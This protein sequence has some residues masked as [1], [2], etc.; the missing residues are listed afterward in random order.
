MVTTVNDA[1][2]DIRQKLR[3]AEIAGSD[4][5]ARELICKAL[6]IDADRFYAKRGEY[7]FDNKISQLKELVALRL[8]GVP[9]QH[10]TGRWEFYGLD[11]KVTPDTLIPR[12]DTETLVDA[13]LA[14][15]NIRP[16]VRVLDLCCGTGCV[17]IAVARF[18]HSPISGL[19]AD[20]SP[21]A[22]HVARENA[23]RNRVS[24]RM[25]VAECDARQPCPEVFGSF[26]LIVCNP[27]Y[28]PSGE[29]D[30]LD[31]EVRREPH[32]ALDGGPD[33]LDF[34]RAVCRNFKAAVREGGAL[35]FEVGLAQH[36]AV[37]K[38][39]VDAGFEDIAVF[40][41]LTGIE[42]VVCGTAPYEYEMEM[43]AELPEITN[44]CT[45][46]CTENEEKRT[47]VVNGAEL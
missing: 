46:N 21:E 2:L 42:R 19:L 27:P 5:E 24:G 7:L 37:Q 35:M 30:G 44:N 3:R 36:E 14:F 40:K 8:S 28:I 34:Y 45:K 18:A 4:I 11:F 33:G 17:G 22:L 23:V 20:I 32:L 25:G 6:E 39:L 26:D 13:A 9:L 16:K 41:D 29:I 47:N 43:H 38:I 10:I 1:Y 31:I 15:V 12:A